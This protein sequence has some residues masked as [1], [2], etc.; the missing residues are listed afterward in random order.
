V[1]GDG[2]D[3]TRHMRWDQHV[4]ASVEATGRGRY[5]R[6]ELAEIDQDMSRLADAADRLGVW[7]LVVLLALGCVVVVVLGAVL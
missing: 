4:D 2:P 3:V 6:P 7:L 5:P 1:T